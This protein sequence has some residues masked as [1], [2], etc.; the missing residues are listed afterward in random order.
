MPSYIR[1]QEVV[2]NKSPLHLSAHVGTL[3][4][5]YQRQLF[6]RLSSLQLALQKLVEGWDVFDLAAN[7]TLLLLLL[8]GGRDW[9]LER[10]ITMLASAAILYR[11]LRRHDTFWFIVTAVL[12]ASNFHNW[13]LIDNHKY[14]ITYWCLA[15]YLSCLTSD[16]AKTIGENA[17]LLIGGAF[18]FATLWKAI[19][20]DFLSGTFF[21][22]S[23]LIDNRFASVAAILGDLSVSAFVQN[24]EAIKALLEYDST[25]QVIQLQDTAKIVVLAK[26]LTWWTIIIEG[27][28]AVAFLWPKGR[29]ISK[30]RNLFLL[31]FLLTTYSIAPVIGFGWVLTIMGF[32]QCDSK[33][34]RL[35][36]VLTFFVLQIYLMPWET[37]LSYYLPVG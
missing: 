26:M 6:G 11:P 19:S 27:L 2:R 18:L 25:L 10:P 13:Y 34:G 8:Y 14:L 3:L 31:A 33:W 32:T 16:P 7:M 23:L 4:K 35:S 29:L 22:Y 1:I 37:I 30:W 20:P 21:H 5:P 12:I 9:Y 15:L 36:Y 24:H 17:R 28:I